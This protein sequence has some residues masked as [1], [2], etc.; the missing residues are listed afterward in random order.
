M[1]APLEMFQELRTHG[2]LASH[3]HDYWYPGL[4]PK[5]LVQTERRYVS[6][7]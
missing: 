7:T 1:P 2:L 3:H 6:V 5:W 4:Y